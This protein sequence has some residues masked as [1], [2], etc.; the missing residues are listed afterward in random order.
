MIDKTIRDKNIDK[1][2][3]YTKPQYYIGINHNFTNI[4][5]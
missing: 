3:V 2:E 4:K 5:K 1:K